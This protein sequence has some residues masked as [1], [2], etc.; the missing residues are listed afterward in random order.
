MRAD[1]TAATGSRSPRPS[2]RSVQEIIEKADLL[3][4]APQEKS[5]PGGRCGHCD[6]SILEAFDGNS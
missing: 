5:V 4:F 6:G 1:S 2:N 3:A